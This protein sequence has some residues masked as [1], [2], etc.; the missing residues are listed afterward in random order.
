[1]IKFFRV[2]PFLLLVWTCFGQNQVNPTYIVLKDIVYNN[3]DTLKADI[4]LPVSYKN[5][6]NP[7]II[8]ADGFGSDFRSWTHYINWAKL[9]AE[10]G[11]VSVLYSSRL[12]QSGECLDKLLR[13]IQ[14]NSQVYFADTSRF[15]L[16]A[17]SG[18]VSTIL[19]LV[20]QDRRIKAALMYYGW[21]K[22][23]NFRVDL[24]VQLVRAGL[25]NTELNKQLDTMAFKAFQ[26]Y[27][28][29]NVVSFNTAGH[30]FEDIKSPEIKQFMIGSLDFLKVNMSNKVRETFRQKEYE[31]AAMRD[32]YRGDWQA[33]LQGFLLALKYDS[34]NNEMERQIGNCYMELKQYQKAIDA[35]NDALTHDN[36]RKG[37][38]A[39]KKCLAYS[40]LGNIAEA[41]SEMRVLKKIGSGWFN[42]KDYE[43]D[44]VYKKV[45]SSQHY[46]DLLKEKYFTVPE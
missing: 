21:A 8:F 41:V 19:P 3:R 42:E 14:D 39:K 1:M 16:Y 25:D 28:P 4:Y 29:Y 10:E 32:L 7:V 35:Y 38:I 46:K 23:K 12:N 17:G 33:A 34:S 27:A 36:W 18:N 37:E 20:N 45:I 9:S 11:F 40:S 31:V 13:Y 43:T 2:L 30:P 22:L 15:S 26:A 24:P 6:F 5:Q 44:L